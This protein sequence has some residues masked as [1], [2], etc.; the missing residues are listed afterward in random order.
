MPEDLYPIAMAEKFCP[1]GHLCGQHTL[2]YGCNNYAPDATANSPDQ[3]DCGAHYPMLVADLRERLAGAE[4]QVAAIR[5]DTLNEAAD[6]LDA[7]ADA[8]VEGVHGTRRLTTMSNAQWLRARAEALAALGVTP[9]EPDGEE[10]TE[11]D[12]PRVLIAAAFEEAAAEFDDADADET[13]LAIGRWLERRSQEMYEAIEFA[14][15]GS[16]VPTEPPAPTRL[17]AQLDELTV[18]AEQYWAAYDAGYA[19][20]T[21]GKPNSRLVGAVPVDEP[22]AEEQQ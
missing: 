2:E 1:C 19:D 16:P 10:R 22:P 21:A 4:R 11:D 18:E 6:E 7:K 5:A 15:A 8:I 3:C 9:T 12:D 14:P 17:H 20:G 13:E